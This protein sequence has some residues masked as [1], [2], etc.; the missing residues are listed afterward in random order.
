MVPSSAGEIILIEFSF[1]DLSRI[2]LRPALV[3]CNLDND[4]LILSQIT[5]NRYS[6]RRA[7]LISED[8]MIYGSLKRIRYIRPGKIFTVHQSIIVSIAGKIIK[9]LHEKV[10]KSI[11]EILNTGLEK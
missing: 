4:E 8:D 5:S 10:I 7:I 2:K 3:I 1:S 9:D 6:D 11:I